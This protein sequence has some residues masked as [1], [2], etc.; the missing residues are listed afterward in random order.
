MKTC[1]TPSMVEMR[2][3]IIDSAY[4]LTSDKGRVA[5][6]SARIRMGSSAGFCFRKEGGFGMSAGSRRC[7]P[8]SAD[9]TSWAAA[10]RSRS[11]LKVTVIR[12]L[13][14]VLVEVI[15]SMPGTVARPCSIGV[16][17]AEAIV[18]GLAPGR[19]AEM[20]RIG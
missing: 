17:T 16:A 7:T 13:P 5:E 20:E 1:E 6:L 10:S 18:S 2:W 11:R 8:D 4:S 19:L 14:R 9:W 3:A 12:V 15:D